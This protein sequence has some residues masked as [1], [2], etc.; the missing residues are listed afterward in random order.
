LEGLYLFNNQFSGCYDANLINVPVGTN[1]NISNGNNFDAP[2]QDFKQ[3]GAGVCNI[4]FPNCRQNDSLILVTL[5]N[6]TD[7]ANWRNTWDL[8]QPLDTWHGV[9]LNVFGCVDSLDLNYNY[10]R[11][12]IPAEL[13]SLGSL[14]FLRLSRNYLNGSIP[15]ELGNLTSLMTLDLDFNYALSGNI[16]TEI[17]NLSNLVHLYLGYTLL[18]GSIPVEISNLSSL[19][20]LHLRNNQLN[21][22]I[23]PSLDNLIQLESLWLYGNQ[24]IGNI[25]SE[26]GNLNKLDDISLYDNQL[27]GSIPPELGKL[28]ELRSLSLQD[29][30]LTG[31]IP[32]E[33]GN[34]YDLRYLSLSNNQLTGSIPPELGNF[35]NLWRLL[36]HNNQISGCYDENLMNLCNQLYAYN[37][38]YG[39]N[40]NISDGNN[41]DTT[42]E[43]F[44]ATGAGTCTNIQFDVKAMLEGPYD[45]TQSKM[46][47]ILNTERGLL[48]GQ[49]P[50][51]ELAAPTPAGQPYNLPPWNYTGREG[52]NFND[53]DYQP[54]VVDW[55]LVSLRTGVDKASEVARVAALL[56]E[57]GCIETLEN[58]PLAT[59]Y[60]G[61]FYIVIE[62]R[63]HMGIM[64]PTPVAVVNGVLQHDFTAQD[65][66]TALGV[67]AGQKAIF[68]MYQMFAGD[69]DQ[70]SDAF[71]YDITGGDKIIWEESNGQFDIYIPADFNLDGDV[72]GAD[73]IPWEVNN[74]TSSRVPK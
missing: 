23:P 59:S 33:L 54:T 30:Q 46:T 26:L 39:T 64:S 68:G 56:H 63:N 1:S 36:L 5:Y 74:G 10:L 62:H 29:N 41:F 32:S 61:P 48:P 52:V 3:N 66:Y 28:D 72:N 27:S 51:S 58:H 12:S 24:L 70:V 34:L 2:W 18:S 11:D 25:P 45:P 71:S 9:T 6:T 69:Y 8:T 13:G 16:P 7:G 44:C 37:T 73:K 65:S 60:Q 22:S 17:G 38:D 4:P 35:R 57:D 20:E 42:W 55:V 15:S 40:E 67:G 31:S 53:T 19:V 21:G 50:S 49:T 14:R 43:D 47:T